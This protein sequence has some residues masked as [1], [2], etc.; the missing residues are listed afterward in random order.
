MEYSEASETE[1]IDLPPGPIVM[2][3]VGRMNPPTPGHIDGL[4]IPMLKSVRDAAIARLKKNDPSKEK[5]DEMSL[6]DLVV[7]A[8]IHPRIYLMHTSNKVK[9]EKDL[10]KSIK[11]IN[12][13][14]DEMPVKDRDPALL[15]GQIRV[16][17]DKNAK[18]AELYKLMDITADTVK[19]KYLENPIEPY[20]KKTFVMKMIVKSLERKLPLFNSSK[21]DIF[22]LLDKWIVCKTPEDEES[23]AAGMFQ[24]I[25]C[26]IALGGPKDLSNLFFFMGIDVDDMSSRDKILDGYI[27]KDKDGVDKFKS[28]T[29]TVLRPPEAARINPMRLPRITCEQSDPE[30]SGTGCIPSMS[31]SKIRLLIAKRDILDEESKSNSELN[32]IYGNYLDKVDII[33]LVKSVRTGL[34]KDLEIKGMGARVGLG[35]EGPRTEDLRAEDLRT[36]DLRAEGTQA[37]DLTR[38]DR[39]DQ[40]VYYTPLA[41]KSKA[42]KNGGRRPTRITMR[43]RINRARMSRLKNKKHHSKKKYRRISATPR[44]TRRARYLKN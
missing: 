37:E 27:G 13:K 36:E 41:K 23:C 10:E 34:Y 20:E 16:A 3:L 25:D 5:T 6:G 31:G 42:T 11:D 8:D 35:A 40:E 9:L 26:A 2:F 19:D 15:K 22:G 32:A 4:C 29:K 28:P 21:E 24:A 44:R 38:K 1:V 30:K 39:S 43:K 14:F 18:T 33:D 12:K 17:K 7:Q